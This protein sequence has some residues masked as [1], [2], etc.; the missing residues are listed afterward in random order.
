M[1]QDFIHILDIKINSDYNMIIQ[2]DS[3]KPERGRLSKVN[4][5]VKFLVAS[6]RHRYGSA[7]AILDRKRFFILTLWFFGFF[8]KLID[9]F[10]P[11]FLKNMLR[12]VLLSFLF[13]FSSFNFSRSFC[14]IKKGKV[15]KTKLE[16][17]LQI[18]DLN[19]H[20]IQTFL[21]CLSSLN[22]IR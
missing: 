17:Q 19:I 10:L 6:I 16:N 13:C 18:Y 12:L 9:T 14:N 1:Y 20:S 4:N 11:P 2:Y 7:I 15:L 3:H 21:S 5:M 8:F 22:L